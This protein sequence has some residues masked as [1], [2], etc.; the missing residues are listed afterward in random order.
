MC[1]RCCPPGCKA[2]QADQSSKPVQQHATSTHPASLPT[3]HTHTWAAAQQDQASGECGWEVHEPRDYYRQDGQY[4]VLADE[5]Q[6][7]Q[8]Q[9]C[10]REEES[11]LST[12]CSAPWPLLCTLSSIVFAT[13][14]APIGTGRQPGTHG[15]R[16]RGRTVANQITHQD[17]HRAGG[18][19]WYSGAGPTAVGVRFGG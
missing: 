3:T 2:A 17:G 15:F 10:W 11:M 1:T 13:A 6:L 16:I 18:T 8:Q 7:Q 9:C 5:S 4:T 19:L 14:A 12:P